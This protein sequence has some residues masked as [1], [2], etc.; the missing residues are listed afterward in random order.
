ML[1]SSEKQSREV[2]LK[3]WGRAAV[4]AGQPAQEF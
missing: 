3:M 1:R 4:L 2:I